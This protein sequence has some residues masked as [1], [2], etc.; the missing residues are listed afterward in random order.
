MSRRDCNRE[1]VESHCLGRI[2]Y[3]KRLMRSGQGLREDFVYTIKKRIEHPRC[4]AITI[5]RHCI[6]SA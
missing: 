6:I 1:I 3:G 5:S 4:L 2:R